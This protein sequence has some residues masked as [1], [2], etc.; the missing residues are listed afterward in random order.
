MSQPGNGIQIVDKRR[1]A[2]GAQQ[3]PA[4]GAQGTTQVVGG[5]VVQT[6]TLPPNP[7]PQKPPSWNASGHPAGA[8]PP[9]RPLGGGSA[10]AP[11]PTAPVLSVTSTQ[12][13]SFAEAMLRLDPGQRALLER[14]PTPTPGV[15]LGAAPETGKSSLT[16]QIFW[17]LGNASMEQAREWFKA[18]DFKIWSAFVAWFMVSGGQLSGPAAEQRIAEIDGPTGEQ[19][20]D[21]VNTALHE[22][23]DDVS[24]A[25]LAAAHSDTPLGSTAR[26]PVEAAGLAAA[27]AALV[28]EDRAAGR[29]GTKRLTK[30]LRDQ[31]SALVVSGATN[32]QISEALAFPVERVAEARAKLAPAPAAPAPA[33]TQTVGTMPSGA[34]VTAPALQPMGSTDPTV[35]GTA[36]APRIE[37]PVDTQTA[38]VHF[39]TDTAFALLPTNKQPPSLDELDKLAARLLA[40]IEAYTEFRGV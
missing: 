13:V 19:A 21:S 36:P 6:T 3:P 7:D 24:D 35:F 4:Q 27:E 29:T 16:D 1:G 33:V 30:A 38:L 39:L 14:M 34:A 20:Q 2:A 28:E 9:A 11:A 18:I 12:A 15:W 40:Q 17:S 10:I 25:E 5:P 37:V 8:R 32:Q 31:I 23:E 22:Q 26:D